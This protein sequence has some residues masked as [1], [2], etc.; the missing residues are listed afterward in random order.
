MLPGRGWCCCTFRFQ[1]E[2][3]DDTL[4]AMDAL[5]PHLSQAITINIGEWLLADAELEINGKDTP[6]KDLILGSKGPQ[7]TV[8]GREWL[9]ELGKRPLSLYEVREVKKGEGLLLADMVHP[10]QPPGG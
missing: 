4:D 6:A 7:L 8:H 1:D 3:D 2:P 10:D 5:S 9:L